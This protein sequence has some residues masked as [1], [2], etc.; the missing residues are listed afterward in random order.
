MCS[1]SAALAKL[2]STTTTNVCDM[3]DASIRGDT[4][5]MEHPVFSLSKKPDMKTWCYDNSASW[6]EVKPGAKGLSTV[7]DLG[8]LNYSSASWWRR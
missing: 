8:I 4:A 1:S 7:F 3:F 2:S 6:V 5:S